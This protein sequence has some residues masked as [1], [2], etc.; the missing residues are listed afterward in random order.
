[1]LLLALF[2]AHAGV[3]KRRREK[4][5]RGFGLLSRGGRQAKRERRKKG[6]GEG[7]REGK[8]LYHSNI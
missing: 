6:E 8:C 2:L 7:D 3:W 1:M 5:L 4:H